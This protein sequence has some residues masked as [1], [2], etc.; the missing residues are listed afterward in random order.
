MYLHVLS[1]VAELLALKDTRSSSFLMAAADLEASLNDAERH[2]RGLR[3]AA[4]NESRS[5]SQE[6]LDD[7]TQL[8]SISQQ[9][10]D[11]V[12]D[13][14]KRGTSCYKCYVFHAC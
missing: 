1:E 7:W 13:R 3:A 2:A 5:R 11:A 10:E 4:A 12:E 6:L 8:T 9:L 14:E